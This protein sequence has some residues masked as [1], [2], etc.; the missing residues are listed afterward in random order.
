MKNLSYLIT[1]LVI[2]SC[3]SNRE[4]QLE[5]WKQEVMETELAFAKMAKIDGI[6]K[7]FEVFAAPDAVLMRNNELIIGKQ[8]IVDLY[9]EISNSNV[10]LEWKPEFIDVA[11]S[12]DLAY[13]YGKYNYSVTDSTGE[14]TSSEGI[15]HTVWKRQED[16][17]WKYVWD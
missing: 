6:P 3:S 12:G 10:K 15:F 17:S 8:S 16:G 13:T 9:N 4:Q 5:E 11:A 1:L 7:A 14:I 2:I